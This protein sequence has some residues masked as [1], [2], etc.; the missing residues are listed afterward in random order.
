MAGLQP[1]ADCCSTVCVAVS[2]DHRVFKQLLQHH[3]CRYRLELD[4]GIRQTHLR[5]HRH[6]AG[7]LLAAAQHT[8]CLQAKASLK[9]R[10]AGTPDRSSPVSSYDAHLSGGCKALSGSSSRMTRNHA[11]PKAGHWNRSPTWVIGQ[12]RN[13]GGSVSWALGSLDAAA[14]AAPSALPTSRLRAGS[15][16]AL[17]LGLS[18]AFHA[19]HL[20]IMTTS[21]GALIIAALADPQRKGVRHHGASCSPSILH[22]KSAH[23]AW[24]QL[25]PA[26]SSTV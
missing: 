13:A 1:L 16:L 14:A 8:R 25:L 3:T 10:P 26:W 23:S 19:V 22:G 20:C 17:R 12:S 4:C 5:A 11:S 9:L 18:S 2:A 7:I 21:H 24:W 6:P 15:T